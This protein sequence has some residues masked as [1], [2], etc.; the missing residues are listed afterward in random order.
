M[1]QPCTNRLGVFSQVD[2]IDVGAYGH[3]AA[4]RPLG[5]LQDTTDHHPLTTIEQLF[6]RGLTV[7]QHVGNVFTDLLHRQLAPAEQAHHRMG[8]TLTHRSQALHRALAACPGDLVEHFDQ[9]RET[10]GRVQIT[11]WNVKAQAFGGQRK[12][13]H[14]Q[15]A[16]AQHDHCGM[17]VDEAGQRLAGDD[18]QANGNDHRDHHHSELVDHAH[19]GNHRIEGEHR[20]EH[21]DLR[22]DGPE[23]R[24]SRIGRALADMAF[25]PFMQLHGRLEQQEHT[26][27]QHD[28]VTPRE[29]LVEHF[30][31]RLG[32]GHQP[33]NTRQQAQA[34]QQRQG[35]ADD[36]RAI[37]LFRRQFVRQNRNEHQ[38]V[39]TQHQL[40]HNQRQQAQPRG[41]VS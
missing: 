33:G 32:Q 27:E 28:Q 39:D 16:Q 8:G 3:Q 24:V 36:T 15:E 10:D 18:H 7:I 11:L 6:A 35:Q 14:H 9:D 23:Q 21:H 1:H 30:E 29:A 41:G 12:A 4:D 2:V 17:R 31:Q 5:Q 26:A 19:G 37:A 40:Q 25:E 13:D 38:V 20:I 22:H 34:H